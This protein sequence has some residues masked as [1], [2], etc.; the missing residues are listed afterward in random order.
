MKSLKTFVADQEITIYYV[1]SLLAGYG[2]QKITAE[3]EFNGSFKKFSATTTNMR[4]FDAAQELEGSDKYH[5]LYEIIESLIIDEVAAW[6]E[7]ILD[8]M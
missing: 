2:H 8:E 6:I 1:G 5:A 3:L 7:E 4:A